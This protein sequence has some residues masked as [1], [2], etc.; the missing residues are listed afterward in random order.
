MNTYPIATEE[1][2]IKVG[3]IFGALMKSMKWRVA[4]LA[5]SPDK[6]DADIG[7]TE[8]LAMKNCWT[9]GTVNPAPSACRWFESSR[10]SLNMSHAYRSL[11][12]QPTIEFEE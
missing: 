8:S 7:D 10:R 11:S 5:L 3:L 6:S 12:S 2:T 1:R 4:G 9:G